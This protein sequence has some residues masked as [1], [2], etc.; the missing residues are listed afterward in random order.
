MK[1]EQARTDHTDWRR[2]V[3]ALRRM[4]KLGGPAAFAK[5]TAAEETPA[6]S[7]PPCFSCAAKFALVPELCGAAIQIVRPPANFLQFTNPI[8][9]IPQRGRGPGA[10]RERGAGVAVGG[11][12]PTQAGAHN[13][14]TLYCSRTSVRADTSR[15]ARYP[16]P[17]GGTTKS[18]IKPSAA[19]IV[20]AM[21]LALLPA[22]TLSFV[23]INCCA[24]KTNPFPRVG[25]F[26]IDI[27]C[28]W[29]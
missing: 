6:G 3:H 16:V 5:A 10:G 19:T 9:T 1:K 13:R 20:G 24:S 2:T 22:A 12:G 26:R 21:Q 15:G 14:P 11:G 25:L 29:L 8:V 4:L 17:T 27:N 28:C 7:A 23:A 18:P